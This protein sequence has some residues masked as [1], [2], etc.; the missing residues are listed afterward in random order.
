MFDQCCTLV[1]SL[2]KE[3]P[4]KVQKHILCSSSHVQALIPLAILLAF[5]SPDAPKRPRP[6]RPSPLRW[7]PGATS[8]VTVAGGHGKGSRPGCSE[9]A[10][11]VERTLILRRVTDGCWNSKKQR[12]ERRE[13]SLGVWESEVDFFGVV[14]WYHSSPRWRR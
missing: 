7:L 4:L 11:L 12:S 5:D 9:G 6:L 1:P 10:R 3:K 14:V 8:G 2:S 13:R